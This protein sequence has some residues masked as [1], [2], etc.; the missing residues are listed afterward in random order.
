MSYKERRIGPQGIQRISPK[1][2]GW[3]TY[4]TEHDRH[5]DHIID[6]LSDKIDPE[7]VH[8]IISN[9]LLYLQTFQPVDEQKIKYIPLE[10]IAFE[11]FLQV[12][13]IAIIVV[14]YPGCFKE[15]VLMID[16][17]DSCLCIDVGSPQKVEF[18]RELKIRLEQK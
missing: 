4:S 12:D 15:Y 17:E 2:D 6:N 8:P 7:T 18:R 13:D 14:E 3:P 1:R 10:A 11:L 5:V 16:S 9:D